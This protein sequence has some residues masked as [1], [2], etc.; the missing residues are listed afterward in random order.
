[1]GAFKLGELFCGPGGIAYGALQAKSNDGAFKIET[2]GQMIMMLI[3]AKHIVR[4]SV[5]TPRKQYVVAM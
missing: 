3:L 5:L 1:M 4:I 2:H